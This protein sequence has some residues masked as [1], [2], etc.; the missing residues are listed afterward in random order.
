M[1]VEADKEALA[2][3]GVKYCLASTLLIGLLLI[4]IKIC[5]SNLIS[6][7]LSLFFWMIYFVQTFSFLTSC[8]ARGFG[9]IKEISVGGVISSASTLLLNILFLVPFHMG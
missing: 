2:T 4:A 6:Y 9:Y 5:D 8:F 1:D 7:E 3:I